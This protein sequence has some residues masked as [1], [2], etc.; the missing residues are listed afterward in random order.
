M[1]TKNMLKTLKKQWV[2]TI[3]DILG[4]S[5]MVRGS[6]ATVYCR[7]GKLNCWCAKKE[8][9]GHPLNR[10]TWSKDGK[11]GIKTIPTEDV[12]W[13]KNMTENY[14]KFRTSRA[15]LRKQQQELKSLLDKL[16]EEIISRTKKHREYL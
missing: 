2:Q 13:I 16:E 6:Y 4:I 12:E 5:L 11:P 8:E 1:S 3:E 15:N 10:I 14:R 9:K 7:C